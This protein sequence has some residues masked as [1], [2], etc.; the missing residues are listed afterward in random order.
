MITVICVV[1]FENAECEDLAVRTIRISITLAQMLAGSGLSS[2][3]AGGSGAIFGRL[4]GVSADGDG[5]AV[6]GTG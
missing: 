6:D 5:V 2:G 1:L 4:G 3:N